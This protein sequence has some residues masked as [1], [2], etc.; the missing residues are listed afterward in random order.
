MATL[1]TP[2]SLVCPRMAFVSRVNFTESDNAAETNKFFIQLDLFHPMENKV[3]GCA[4]PGTITK[5]GNGDILEKSVGIDGGLGRFGS[6]FQ[7]FLVNTLG[8]KDTL[9]FLNNI[10]P[11]INLMSLFQSDSLGSFTHVHNNAIVGCVSGCARFDTNSPFATTVWKVS[12]L[13]QS[14]LLPFPASNGWL[15]AGVATFSLS[16]NSTGNSPSMSL[17]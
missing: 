4:I 3:S 10:L 11:F 8:V 17:M 13:L 9:V 15:A 14:S 12:T 6:I 16:L 5:T 7:K 2:L 1:C